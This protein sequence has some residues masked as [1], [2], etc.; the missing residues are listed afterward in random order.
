MIR[1]MRNGLAW[2]GIVG[3]AA[4]ALGCEPPRPPAHWQ[5]GGGVLALPRARWVQGDATVDLL[6]QG[7][8]LV[9]GRHVLS[10]DA[11]GRVFEPD[12][13]PVALLEPT[14]AVVG[15][16]NE[17]LGTVGAVTAARPG[18][19]VAWLALQP[20]G[21]VV[22]FG[23]RGRAR[24]LGVWVGCGSAPQ[25]R[26]S[27]VLLSHLLAGQLLERRAEPPVTFGVGVGV[28]VGF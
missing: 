18:Q 9:D 5:Q 21:E 4:A 2:A 15:P 3:V 14:G 28:G 27:C 20:S 23:R 6:P 12:G 17:D 1:L 13:S 11:A 7:K 16:D 10:L 22:L 8:V 19:Q 24:P 26:Q 25:G